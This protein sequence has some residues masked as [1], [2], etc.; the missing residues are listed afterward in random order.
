VICEAVVAGVMPTVAP[1]SIR[2]ADEYRDGRF[3]PTSSLYSVDEVV[4]GLQKISYV[5]PRL[6]ICTSIFLYAASPVLDSFGARCT[7]QLSQPHCGQH[8]IT[9][10]LSSAIVALQPT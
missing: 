4:C 2:N 5:V 1:S 7:K 10:H 6:R 9:A 8:F 3:R